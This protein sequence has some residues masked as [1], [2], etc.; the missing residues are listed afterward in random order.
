MH[1]S[2]IDGGTEEEGTDEEDRYPSRPTKKDRRGRK[3]DRERRE[4]ATYRDR[5][6]GVQ[7]TLEKHLNP[8]NTKQ[9]GNAS[10]GA[11]TMSKGK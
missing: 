6:A 3:M 10:K 1:E 4:T 5:L 8:R 7:T 9:Q 11:A 2:A